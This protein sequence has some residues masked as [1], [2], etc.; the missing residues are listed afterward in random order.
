[1]RSGNYS[2][3]LL[4][5]T[6]RNH[7][8]KI[9]PNTFIENY[10]LKTESEKMQMILGGVH[11]VN[12]FLHHLQRQRRHHVAQHTCGSSF[13]LVVASPTAGGHTNNQTIK[14]VYSDDDNNNTTLHQTRHSRL[15]P[16][17]CS[18]Q[19]RKLQ[20]MKPHHWL[21]DTP[22]GVSAGHRTALLTSPGTES[23]WLFMQ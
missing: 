5:K 23:H 11:G 19:H 2:E 18:A 13:V 22:G 20:Q 6:I 10:R 17:I 1:M 4:M 3:N 8:R 9:F 14:V 12:T 7:S 21:V 16:T 15:F